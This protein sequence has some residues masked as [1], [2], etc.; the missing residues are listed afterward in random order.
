MQEMRAEREAELAYCQ[1]MFPG[2]QVPKQRNV[3]INIDDESY[4][5]I[6]EQLTSFKGMIF[7]AW[8]HFF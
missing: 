2:A 8:Y 4:A 1:R 3:E 5:D 7:D 6:V